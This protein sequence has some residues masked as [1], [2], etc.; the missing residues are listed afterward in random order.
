VLQVRLLAEFLV[1]YHTK[2]TR[3]RAG[4]NGGGRQDEGAGAVMLC[5]C[6]GEVHKDILPWGKRCP[7]PPVPLQ[8]TLVDSLQYSAVLFC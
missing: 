6:F 1:E 8:A 2:N 7:M 3:V 5:P 4:V